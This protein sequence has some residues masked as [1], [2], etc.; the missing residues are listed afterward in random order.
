MAVTI[1][2]LIKAVLAFSQ[3]LPE[4]LLALGYNILK[5]LTGN[6]NFPIPPVDALNR[7]VRGLENE[8]FFQ[9]MLADVLGPTVPAP[10]MRPQESARAPAGIDQPSNCGYRAAK[11]HPR[12]LKIE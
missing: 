1:P 4:Q 12:S 3:M 2:K 11:L 7:L 5:A 10:D 9:K 6:A 8:R